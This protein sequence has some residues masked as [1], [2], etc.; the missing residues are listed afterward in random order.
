MSTTWQ[1]AY[2][3]LK[4]LQLLKAFQELGG[5]LIYL[6]AFGLGLGGRGFQSLLGG[7]PAWRGGG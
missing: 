6:G 2:F 7:S 1:V 3:R 4:D 5:I